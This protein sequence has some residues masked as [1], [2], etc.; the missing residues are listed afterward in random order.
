MIGV[1]HGHWTVGNSQGAIAL[2]TEG[3]VGRLTHHAGGSVKIQY[4]PGDLIL[5][6]DL[7][8]ALRRTFGDQQPL[9]RGGYD[10]GGAPPLEVERDLVEFLVA[11]S[12]QVIVVENGRVERALDTS[13]K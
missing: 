11:G 6:A 8:H 10:D 12:I 4:G 13:F 3:L 1:L 9:V 5:G 2:C 7:Q